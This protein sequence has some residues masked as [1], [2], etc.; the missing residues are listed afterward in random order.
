MGLN[1]I[2]V[3]QAIIDAIGEMNISSAPLLVV[4]LKECSQILAPTLVDLWQGGST[5]V[6]LQ[7]YSSDRPL[8]LFSRR[9]TEASP[10]TTDLYL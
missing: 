10:R 5:L 7:R 4:I 2:Y 6:S 8:S 1:D 3:T 9:G